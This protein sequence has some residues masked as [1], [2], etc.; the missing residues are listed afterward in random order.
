MVDMENHFAPQSDFKNIKNISFFYLRE[1]N[2]K[3]YSV[4]DSNSISLQIEAQISFCNLLNRR[5]LIKPPSS[6]SYWRTAVL[7]MGLL[8]EEL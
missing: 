8:R 3:K 1:R 7:M 6:V 2:M 5:E 4:R